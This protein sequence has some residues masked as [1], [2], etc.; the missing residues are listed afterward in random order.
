[1]LVKRLIPFKFLTAVI[2]IAIAGVLAS[3]KSIYPTLN[4]TSDGRYLCQ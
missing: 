1:M 4:N 3:T 2:G